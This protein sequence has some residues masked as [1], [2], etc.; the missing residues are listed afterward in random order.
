MPAAQGEV[1]DREIRFTLRFRRTITITATSASSFV[2]GPTQRRNAGLRP[3][4]GHRVASATVRADHGTP[5]PEFTSGD[6]PTATGGSKA[7]RAASD[8]YELGKISAPD[9]L[10]PVI[11]TLQR[12]RAFR[13]TNTPREDKGVG[14][15]VRTRFH[16]GL[17]APVKLRIVKDT[18]TERRKACFFCRT[19]FER[20]ASFERTLF[21]NTIQPFD[22]MSR[23]HPLSSTRAL[24][25]H[26]GLV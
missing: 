19:G 6:A 12:K 4:I 8:R 5:D 20:A 2:I 17:L 14:E 3:T 16:S 15:H 1:T 18:R 7:T 21:R 10:A 9:A 23:R 25:F 22:L 13:G 11:G 24:D 26:P